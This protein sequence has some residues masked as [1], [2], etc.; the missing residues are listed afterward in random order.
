MLRNSEAHH[1]LLSCQGSLLQLWRNIAIGAEASSLMLPRL[2]P[3]NLGEAQ[4]QLLPLQRVLAY[5]AHLSTNT[6][7]AAQI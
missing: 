4:S 7:L 6:L 5:L 2:S 3:S 1:T